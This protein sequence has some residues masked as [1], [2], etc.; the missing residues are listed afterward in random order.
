MSRVWIASVKETVSSEDSPE[1]SFD[2]VLDALTAGM[3]EGQE[4][5][6]SMFCRRYSPSLHR[7]CLK[8]VKGDEAASYELHQQTLIRIARYPKQIS[9]ETSLWRWMSRVVRTT[10]IDIHRKQKRYGAAMKAYWEHIVTQPRNPQLS[11][12]SL[13]AT[14]MEVLAEMPESD[15]ELIEKKYL[16]GWSYQALAE[17]LGISEKAVESRL[18]RA[19]IKLREKALV[20][21][22]SGKTDETL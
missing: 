22:K 17:H 18:T 8:I 21:L 4:A 19:R 5:D 12:S 6:F 14:L 20:S 15:R 11:D 13:S 7:Y 16:G 3:V 2:S 10:Q 1:S 9:D